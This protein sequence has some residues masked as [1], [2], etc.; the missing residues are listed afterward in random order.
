MSE[1][2]P[3]V[4]TLL[5]WIVPPLVFLDI[6]KNKREEAVYGPSDNVFWLKHILVLNPF[7]FAFER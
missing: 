2:P 3:V 5:Q 1:N 4:L 7:I 6:K